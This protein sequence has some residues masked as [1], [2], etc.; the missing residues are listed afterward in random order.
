MSRVRTA[1]LHVVMP[2]AVGGALYCGWRAESLVGWRWA[3]GIGVDGAARA[4]RAA[5]RGLELP[6]PELVVYV[7]PD[8]LWVYALTFALA[9]LHARSA[10]L[11]RAL[12]LS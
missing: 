3:E 6:L 2:L 12:V 11:E 8:A 4:L 10:R 1:L 7:L 9:R 5:L